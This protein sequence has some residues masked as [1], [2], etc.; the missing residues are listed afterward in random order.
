MRLEAAGGKFDSAVGRVC[1]ALL[2]TG[3]LESK[4]N[5]FYVALAV[6]A[7]RMVVH[8]LVVANTFDFICIALSDGSY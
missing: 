1:P 2:T 3:T 8:R 7:S 6:P 4:Y 5:S